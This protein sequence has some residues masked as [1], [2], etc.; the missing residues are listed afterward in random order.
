MQLHSC[1][2]HR[3]D[4]TRLL[5]RLKRRDEHRQLS[6]LFHKYGYVRGQ[7]FFGQTRREQRAYPQRS[8][9]REQPSLAEKELPPGGLRRIWP[10]AALLGRSSIAGDTLSPSR[11]ASGQIGRIE[12]DRI[13]ETDHLVRDHASPTADDAGSISRSPSRET[14]HTIPAHNPGPMLNAIS[15]MLQ[16]P[17]VYP[18]RRLDPQ[19]LPTT[20]PTRRITADP[21][22]SAHCRIQRYRFS[23]SPI[24]RWVGLVATIGSSILLLSCRTSSSSPSATNSSST[25]KVGLTDSGRIVLPVSQILTPAGIQ[26]EL[27]G[28]RPQALAL[29]PDGRLLVTSGKSHELIVVD[30]NTGELR[31]SVPLPSEKGDS[32]SADPVS[33]HILEP[34]KEGQLSFTGLIFSQD[35]KRIYL[36]NVNGSVKVFAVEPDLEVRPLRTLA[37]PPTGRIERQEEIPSGL[38]LSSDGKRLFVVLNLS[39]QLLEIDAASGQ[40]LRRFDVGFAPYDV[41]L[42]NHKAYVSNWGG[43]R[44][45]SNSLTGPAGRGT[46]VRVDPVRHIASEGSLSIINLET[47]QVEREI[48]LGLHSSGLALAPNGRHLAIA[49]AASDTVSIVDTRNDRVVETISL[50][51]QPDEYFGASPNALTFDSSGKTLY[52][53][54][55]THN[56][57]AVVSFRPGHSRLR[58]L[59]P[60]GWFPGAIVYDAARRM[61]Q[62]ANIKGLGSGRR[63]T[64]GDPKKFNSHQYFG[65]LSLVPVPN[66]RRL[67]EHTRQVLANCRRELIEATQLPPR[68]DQPARPVPTRTGERSLF[69]HVV[70][71][72]KENR[73]YDQVLGDMPEGNGDA[74]LCVFGEEVTPNQ[75]KIAREFTLL[76]N[77]YCSGILSAD[78]HNWS[79]AAFATDYLE[80]SFAGW[81]RSYPDGMEDDDVDALAYSPSGFLWDSAMEHG[82]SLRVY[83]EFAVTEKSWKDPNRTG[84]IRWT[85]HYRDF[86]DQTG[87]IRI[88]SRPAI[89]SLRPV[90][91]T[92]TVGWDMNIPDIF[93]ADQFIRELKQFERQGDFPRLAI[94]CLPND[95]TSGTSEGAPTPA[96]QVADND[97]AL[98]RII[99]AITHSRF[100][101]KTCVFAIEDDPQNGWDHVSGFRTTAYVVSPYTKRGAVVSTQYNQPGLLRTIEL[102][103]GLPPMN[104]M[105]AAATPMFDAFSD[106]PNWTPFDAVPNRVPLDEMNPPKESIRDP[107]LR[108]HAELSANLPLE[109]VDQCDEDL[110][111]RILW[112]A[113]KGSSAPYPKWA[114][115]PKHLRE[116]TD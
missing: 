81:P 82:R 90:L 73:T 74:S 78:G 20:C 28:L 116:D 95:H 59:I 2:L 114:I 85:D 43:R 87:L 104:Q 79:T 54:N 97:L 22:P 103:L 101:P 34:D 1:P 14:T 71:I 12:R 80:R 58:G 88:F 64:P 27:P 42:A 6:S 94:I 50:R 52:V 111:N 93:R 49:N 17:L 107:L 44:P 21:S 62:V 115:L 18:A 3:A 40:P 65:S 46:R 10:G 102:I 76:D 68:P 113:R 33:G 66:K 98:G 11:L 24:S 19:S 45:D 55:G 99:E 106:V 36:A 86:V 92:N 41:V 39:N 38:A 35:G 23:S 37:L 70:Y 72:I 26:V 5:S 61:L 56:A 63:T 31:Q 84:K 32:S 100:W 53:C 9:R 83:G 25:E 89:E 4:N 29:S 109:R 96:A 30:P 69:E 13:Y 77:T 75:H 105:D 16:T 60:V 8:V 7:G 47:E 57:I 91:C 110:L 15:L 108:R 67:I 112:Y 51:W 48:L